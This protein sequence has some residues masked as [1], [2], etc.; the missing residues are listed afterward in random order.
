[1]ASTDIRR[2]NGAVYFSG[3]VAVNKYTYNAFGDNDYSPLEMT[4]HSASQIV[5]R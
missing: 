5:S 1:M 4:D 3:P 2:I